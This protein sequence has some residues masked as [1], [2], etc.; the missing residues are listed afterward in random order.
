MGEF[1]TLGGSGEGSQERG[2]LACL[3]LVEHDCV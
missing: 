1:R 2:L 3:L